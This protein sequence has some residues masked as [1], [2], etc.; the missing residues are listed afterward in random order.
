MNEVPESGRAW[1]ITWLLA[2]FMLI[3]FLDKIVLGLVAVPMMDELRLTPKQF[4][5]IGS[6]FF[7]L[8]AVGGV[9][10]GFLA[11]R[12]RAGVLILGMGL[13]WSVTQLPIGYTASISVIVICR[14]VL[15][16]AQGPAWPVAVHALYK[17]FPND[18]RNVP[19]S[20]VA[21]GSTVG[22][23]AAGVLIPLITASWGWRAN[24]VA[25]AVIGCVWALIWLAV[26]EEGEEDHEDAGADSVAL[27]YAHLLFD[28]SVLGCAITH[29]VGYWS[30][31]LT[32]TWL[33]AYFQR[34]L[35]FGGIASGWLYSGVVGLMIPFGIGLAWGSEHLLKRGVPSKTARGRYL[36]ALLMAAGALLAILYADLPE[37]LRIGLI[38]VALG[39]T[40][41]VYSLGPA[42]LAEVVPVPQRGSML[43]IINSVASLA[44]IAAPVV[45]GA[46]IE[47]VS[48]AR[49][50]ELGF[51]LCGALMVAGGLLGLWMIDPERS[52]RYAT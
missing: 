18:R 47:N 24:F 27:S 7:W 26:A 48:G 30:L 12:V 40:P 9:L 31:A 52:L 5:D 50:F 22:M 45:T 10:G 16:A 3:N 20:V 42:V 2:V 28:R 34:G 4:G 8:F 6:G 49:G 11:N 44:G 37:W 33:P 51:A 39:C 1:T 19:I 15:G 38:A 17:W 41:I 23:V 43:A 32:L 35:G 29:F 21:Q 36:S 46:L 25:L 13:I 14:A